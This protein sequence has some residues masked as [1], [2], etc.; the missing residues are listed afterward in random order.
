MLKEEIPA[1]GKVWGK[2]LWGRVDA[3]ALRQC[4]EAEAQG[5]VVKAECSQGGKKWREDFPA[6]QLAPAR[7]QP[8]PTSWSHESPPD[9]LVLKT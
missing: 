4:S 6:N 5:I 7:G 1:R 2:M 3:K 8:H 9:S